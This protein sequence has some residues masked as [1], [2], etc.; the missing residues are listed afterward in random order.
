MD[1]TN[2]YWTNYDGTVEKVG[3]G[4]GMAV[5]LT[6]GLGEGTC[7]GIAVDATSVYWGS[8][9][10]VMKMS[11]GGGAL[12]PLASLENGA[13]A[14]AI[15]KTNVYFT[16]NDTNVL[17]SVALGG[18]APPVMLGAPPA[19]VINGMTIDSKNVYLTIDSAVMKVPLGGGAMTTLSLQ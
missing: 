7:H 11:L 2:V 18:G 10:R 15:D 6:P 3:K 8:A 14:I 13:D 9:A 19:L 16:E 12:A 4:G 17:G 5:A 1:S